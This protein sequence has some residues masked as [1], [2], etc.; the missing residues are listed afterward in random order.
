MRTGEQS[1]ARYF[2]AHLATY[3]H[4]VSTLCVAP[5]VVSLHRDNLNVKGTVNAI[6]CKRRNATGGYLHVPDYGATFG[7]P[8]G[9]LLVYPAWRNMHGVTPIRET[10]KG[11]YRNSLI[12]YA[13]DAF[14]SAP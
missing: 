5:P 3:V 10:H 9:S 6:I 4:H 8:D 1:D 14:G 11:G 12:W 7:Q 13:L 2:D